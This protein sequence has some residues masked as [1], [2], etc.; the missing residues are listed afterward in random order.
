MA[1]GSFVVACAAMRTLGRFSV[2]ILLAVGVTTLPESPSTA[3]PSPAGRI[4]FFSG[5]S[6]S[7][8]DLAGSPR[9]QQIFEH[10]LSS[11][12][13][14]A[15]LYRLNI[16]AQL[17][18]NVVPGL[19]V[20]LRPSDGRLERLSNNSWLRTQHVAW[21]QAD[22]MQAQMNSLAGDFL[23]GSFTP[24][25]SSGRT[26]AGSVTLRRAPGAEWPAA[27]V[28]VFIAIGS[29]QQLVSEQ[30]AAPRF[31]TLAISDTTLLN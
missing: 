28:R 12:A 31:T 21:E 14:A 10:P 13:A 16:A 8:E 22:R 25:L 3:Q 20:L 2:L 15:G 19:T 11:I 18:N 27:G 6:L 1:R 7:N 9:M 26:V 30:A 17:A 23:V 4:S 24:T 5:N 29:L